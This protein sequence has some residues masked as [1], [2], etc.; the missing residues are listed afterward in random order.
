MEPDTNLA[1]SPVR[2]HLIWLLGSTK[3]F[4]S[5]KGVEQLNVPAP[6]AA[7]LGAPAAPSPPST[8]SRVWV[9]PRAPQF[10]FVAEQMGRNCAKK[11]APPLSAARGIN[12][13]RYSN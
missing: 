4:S 8:P 9:K 5:R 1:L 10:W 6:W 12:P 11:K 3:E 2:C 13:R 7:S